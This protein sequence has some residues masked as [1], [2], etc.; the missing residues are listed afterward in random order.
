MTERRVIFVQGLQSSMGQNGT[1]R[2][3]RP[4]RAIL[5]LGNL[6]LSTTKPPEKSSKPRSITN[7]LMCE[8]DKIA[9]TIIND[10]ELDEMNLDNL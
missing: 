5:A 6:Y 10:I 2:C 1:V 4:S 3:I 7:T 9:L 8:F